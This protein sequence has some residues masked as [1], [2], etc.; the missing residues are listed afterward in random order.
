M[1]LF[2]IPIFPEGSLR[3]SVVTTVWIGVIVISLLNLRFGWT[4]SGLVV[5]GYLVPLIYLNPI[6]AI[7]T[8]VEG[9]IAY[10]L[11]WLVSECLPRFAPWCSFFGRDRFFA[12]LLSAVSVRVT[13]D[14]YALPHLA[15]WMQSQLGLTLD[16][17]E[18]FRSF[19]LVVS[20]LIANQFW[21]SGLW[22]GLPP[23]IIT[24]GITY[25][26]VR[27]GL[28]T[29]TNFTIGHIAYMYSDVAA[30][31]DASPKS[32][33]ILLIAGFIASRMNLR[34][35]LD[36][37]GI[38]IPALL[39]LLWYEPVRILSTVTEAFVTLF[40]SS[41]L[42]R[43]PLFSGLTMEGP[44]K[45]LLF[46][47]VAYF[48]RLCLGYVLPHV[49]PG[50]TISDYYGF[51]YL[52]SS[53]IAIKM[54]SKQIPIRLT[55]S[56]LQTALLAAI[57]AN[58][59]GL[60]LAMVFGSLPLATPRPPRVTAPLKIVKG[61][62]Q[63]T[64]LNEKVD[65]YQKLIPE[66]YSPPTPAQLN[67]FRS[68]M[69]Q[70]KK[71]LQ[72]G[73][74]ELLEEV[75]SLL[76]Q[77]HYTI[78]TIESKF[79]WIHEDG[80]NQGW[81]HFIINLNNPEGLLISIPAPLD[82]WSTMEAGI[83]LFSTLDCGALA[84]SSTGR[85]VNKD[86]SSDILANP[87]T[88]FQ[89]FHQNFGRGNTLQI[90]CPIDSSQL[91]SRSGEQQTTFLWIK[92][93]LPKDLPL[94][95]LQELVETEIQLVWQPGPPPNVQQK[96]SRGG[97]A[98][99]WLSK[100]DANTLR[101]KFATGTLASYQQTMALTN[102]LVA[103]L[104]EQKR[105][106]PKRGTGLYQ[107]PTPAQLLYIDK[108]VLTPL[109]DLV[110]GKEFGAELLHNQM[111]VALNLSANVIGYRVFSVWDLQTQS[112]YIVVTE[113][114]ESPV[115]KYWGTYV[116]RAG[117]RQP[118]IIEVP[119]PLFEMNTLEFGVFLMQELEAENLSI[120]G[121]HNPANPAGMA[122][123]L[124]PLNP[125]TLFNLV[126]QVQLRE[127]KSTPKLVIQCRGYSPQIV[128]TNIPEILISSA[129]DTSEEQTD[130][131]LI[132]KLLHQFNLLKFDYKFIDGSLISAGYEAYGT[133]QALYLNQTINKDL[134]TLWLSPFFREA[135]RPQENYPILV[136]FRNIDLK[137]IECDVERLLL[138][139][140]TQG[141]KT[142]LPRELREKLLLYVA[143]MDITLLTQIV[144]NWPSYSFTPALDTQTRQLYLLISHNNHALPAVVNLRPRYIDIQDTT[145][146]IT[147]AE[148]IKNF[149]KLRIP[150]L[151]W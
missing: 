76:E 34:Y 112:P 82:E 137:P 63:H 104:L 41:W 10:S 36:Y 40:I 69:E 8:V 144:S 80:Q 30:S 91:G 108:E 130:S 26:I 16:Y 83:E 6:C 141:Q 81:G 97:F 9:I 138:D 1:D 129:T 73:Q 77:V 121:I 3:E 149:L 53:L 44:R 147:E 118:Y 86:R 131:A 37:S 124:N 136:Q 5:P 21:K 125:S 64:L 134:L 143:T 19:G 4:Y 28:M 51:A 139:R 31:L 15:Q 148:K 46:F 87:Y 151:D 122:D 75:Q 49:A 23:F 32:Y 92:I 135:F 146:G 11:V 105:N 7:I 70:L 22:R 96:I 90:R 66:T 145:P 39:G 98:E 123:V 67:Y 128:T 54:H 142:K 133:P 107:A 106:L 150:V 119:R 68:A 60:W 52:L 62:L 120:A 116:F 55:R 132:Q 38:L 2:P 71:Y 48:Y 74:P 29:L 88:F 110:S 115:K 117:K 42:L 93:Q 113:P 43:T 103:W 114:D 79:L 14:G 102:S 12:L 95:K 101:A 33:I 89:V 127:S 61:D 50:I 20:A 58:F 78:E 17:K 94:K 140:L 27:Y 84:I 59:L 35:G 57:G 24:T 45:V 47:N 56:V 126:H 25:L 18:W 111:L 109:M 100:N 99:L 13:V 85:F 65:M 72:T